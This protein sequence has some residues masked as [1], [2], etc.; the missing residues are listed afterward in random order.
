MKLQ[1]LGAAIAALA[2]FA[3]VDL[4]GV[5][6]PAAA[7]QLAGLTAN[8]QLV[9]FDSATPSTTSRISVTG[10][11]GSL[12]GIDLRPAN[13][14]IY[15]LSN[16]NNIYTI[17]PFT[18]QATFI[19]A[20]STAFNGGTASGIDFN[21]VPDRLRIVGSNDQNLRTNVDTGATIVDG[22]LN[23]ENPN[24]TA[25]AYTN[26]DTDPAT[27]TTLYGIDSVEDALFIQD[28]PN[29]GTLNLVGSLGI[30]FGSTGGFDIVTLDGA[31]LAFAVTG[32]TLYSINLASGAVTTLGTVGDGSDSFIGLTAT[33]LPAPIPTPALLPGLIGM[34]LATWKKRKGQQSEGSTLKQA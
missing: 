18:G 30:D 13:N 32:P 23:P 22:T 29:N 6:N 8:N 28:P 26:V 31:N 5:A 20:L 2:T 7:I 16:T 33:A 14:T 24:I 1:S 34:G 17:N 15:G 21:P 3:V 11:N 9:L 27:G 10:V 12:L 4:F 25:S 19:S